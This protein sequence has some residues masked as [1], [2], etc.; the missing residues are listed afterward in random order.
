MAIAARVSKRR[1]RGSRSF[2]QK[3]WKDSGWDVMRRAAPVGNDNRESTSRHALRE[4]LRREDR[5][6]HLGGRVAQF[7]AFGIEDAKL[8]Q[9]APLQKAFHRRAQN[10]KTVLHAAAE[11][12]GRSLIEVEGGAGDFADAESEMERLHDHFVVEDEIVGIFEQ[13]QRLQHV[14]AESAKARV[15]FRK[16]C[17]EQQVLG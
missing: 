15:I 9:A 5:V 17:V 10:A 1:T 12:N 6:A 4:L 13:R 16:F 7:A 3:R 11:A 8:S 2:G 14:A